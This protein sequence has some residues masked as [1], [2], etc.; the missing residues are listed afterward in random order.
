MPR[1]FLSRLVDGQSYRCPVVRPSDR[2]SG[3]APK[4]RSH[5]AC[6]RKSPR[7]MESEWK[8]ILVSRSKRACLP[9]FAFW[10]DFFFRFVFLEGE[11]GWG[12][13]V[14]CECERDLSSFVLCLVSMVLSFNR[15]MILSILSVLPALFPTSD[16]THQPRRPSTIG[17]RLGIEC[18]RQS[19]ETAREILYAFA[20]L[21]LF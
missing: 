7:G 4:K 13:A 8:E 11:G 3:L 10:V 12:G 2:A 1:P 5:V 14:L 9:C 21:V 6:G 17:A 20:G 16:S 19:L 18:D 15:F